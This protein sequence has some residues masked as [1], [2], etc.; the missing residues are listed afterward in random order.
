MDEKTERK[1][2]NGTVLILNWILLLVQM[3]LASTLTMF[4]FGIVHAHINP[5]W[6]AIGF[7]QSFVLVSLGVGFVAIFKYI[8]PIDKDEV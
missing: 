4:T 7:W 5:Y 8:K 6:D 1:I 3:L 2:I